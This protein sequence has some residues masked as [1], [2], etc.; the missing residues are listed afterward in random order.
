MFGDQIAGFGACQR[1]GTD[2]HGQKS[3]A[4]TREFLEPAGQP[5]SGEIALLDQEGRT[6]IAQPL[7]VVRLVVV[8]LPCVPAIA[9][10]WR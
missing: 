1:T 7:R 6:R 3:G 8:V 4:I 2:C 9:M 10:P 5:L